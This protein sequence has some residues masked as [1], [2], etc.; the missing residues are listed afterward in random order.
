[1]TATAGRPAA[2]PCQTPPVR[3]AALDGLRA[4]AIG[5]VVVRHWVLTAY[6]VEGARFTMRA[7]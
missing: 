6:Y 4:M 1:M 5:A 2:Y 3:D 7:R